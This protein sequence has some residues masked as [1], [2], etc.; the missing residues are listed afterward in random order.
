MQRAQEG[1]VQVY[2]NSH[3]YTGRQSAGRSP[4]CYISMGIVFTVLFLS[5]SAFSSDGR[6]DR[7]SSRR[8][9]LP[10]RRRT[11]FWDRSTVCELHVVSPDD[12]PSADSLTGFFATSPKR[13]FDLPLA[14]LSTREAT[15]RREA[16]WGAG[17]GAVL[18]R[19]VAEWRLARA[20]SRSWVCCLDMRDVREPRATGRMLSSSKRQCTRAMLSYVIHRVKQTHVP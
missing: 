6:L 14:Q 2:E 10:R 4:N 12:R 16:E 7:N 19:L 3:V 18:A 15:A 17:R 8:I 9:D 11:L 20:A 1:A 5:D 13:D